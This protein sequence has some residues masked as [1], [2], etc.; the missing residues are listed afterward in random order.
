LSK[1]LAKGTD[2]HAMQT[3]AM[4][5]QF[6][7]DR[8][9]DMLLGKSSFGSH[10]HFLCRCHAVTAIALAV[11]VRAKDVPMDRVFP[12]LEVLGVEVTHALSTS[13][14]RRVN[15]F[16]LVGFVCSCFPVPVSSR[17]CCVSTR[18]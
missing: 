9:L 17:L 2:W 8:G 1:E 12:S 10:K 18:G 13:C 4:T 15:T 3:E 6:F 14:L 7:K 16:D 5:R 11:G